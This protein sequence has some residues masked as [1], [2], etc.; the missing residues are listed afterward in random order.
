[1]GGLIEVFGLLEEDRAGRADLWTNIRYLVSRL[2]SLGF[3]T[4]ATHSA[5]LPIIIG[6]EAKLSDLHRDLRDEGIF[7]SVVTYPA[8]RRKECRLRLSLMNSHTRPQLDRVLS[9]LKKLG[10]KHGIID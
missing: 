10:A 7:T 3:D 4:G 1:M 8:V 2:Q 6:D 9:V 5:I